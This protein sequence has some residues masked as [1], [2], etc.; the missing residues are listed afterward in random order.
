MCQVLIGDEYLIAVKLLIEQAQRSVDVLMYRTDLAFSGAVKSSRAL[1]WALV[2]A[3]RAGA[4]VR[5]VVDFSTPRLAGQWGN[6]EAARWL[7]ERDVAVRYLSHSQLLHEKL[8]VVD[9]RVAVVGSHNWSAASLG[10]NVEASVGITSEAAVSELAAQFA[11]L[12]T[13]SVPFAFS[14]E[15]GQ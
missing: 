6:V 7:A 13:H 8:L 11:E 15:R 2:K 3:K 14:R 9:R 10:S 5:V 4:M 12:W 1:G